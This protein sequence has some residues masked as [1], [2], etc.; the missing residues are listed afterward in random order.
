M[1]T[2]VTLSIVSPHGKNIALGRKTIEVRSWQPLALPIK[3]LL[4]IE[5][6][7]YLTQEG[8]TD[9]DGRA[10]ALVDVAFIEPWMPSQVEA[11]CSNGWKSGYFAWH[12]ENVRPLIPSSRIMAARKLYK[13]ELPQIQN[14]T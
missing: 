3:D 5:N 12:L 9:P 13:V 4:I 1:A 7:N 8:Q 2:Y 6:D 11:A 14:G 10:V